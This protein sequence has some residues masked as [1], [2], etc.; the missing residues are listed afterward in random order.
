[1]KLGL[2][3]DVTPAWDTAEAIARIIEADVATMNLDFTLE[4]YFGERSTKK[5]DLTVIGLFEKFI[6]HKKASQGTAL[7]AL[8]TSMGRVSRI[9]GNRAGGCGCVGSVAVALGG[10]AAGC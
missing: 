5:A 6:H 3:A 4:K 2:S 9:D 10:V 7:V 8:Q 1:M